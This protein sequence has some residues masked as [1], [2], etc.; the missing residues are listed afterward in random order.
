MKDVPGHDRLGLT[1]QRR[2][3][4]DLNRGPTARDRRACG[5]AVGASVEVA[6]ELDAEFAIRV[7]LN[8]TTRQRPIAGLLGRGRSPR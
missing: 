7:Q 2:K 3:V 8:V 1:G 4:D 5:L 6:P